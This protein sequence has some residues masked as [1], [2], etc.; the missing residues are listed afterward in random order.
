MGFIMRMPPR[1]LEGSHDVA[2]L[3]GQET[4]GGGHERPCHEHGDGGPQIDVGGDPG[5]G[6]TERRRDPGRGVA[7]QLDD[8]RRNH[9]QHQHDR[10]YRA[11]EV[12]DDGAEPGAED[13]AD[14]SGERRGREELGDATGR[15]Q[16]A[17]GGAR[18]GQRD[19]TR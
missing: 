5:D 14:R 6:R 18:Q 19:A 3:D 11:A 1:P 16:E 15:D 9:E 17:V 2:S 4:D 12:A 8:E 7:H 13:G 10:G